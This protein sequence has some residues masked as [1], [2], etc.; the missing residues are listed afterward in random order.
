VDANTVLKRSDKVTFQTV[1]GE[2]ILIRMDSGTYFSLNQVGT[3]F[4]QLL[5]GRSP[6]SSH[7]AHIAAKYNERTQAFFAELA[8]LAAQP[9]EASQ[10][11]ITNLA[12]NYNLSEAMVRENRNRL[13][14]GQPAEALVRAYSVED[15]MVLADLLELAQKL[16]AE[17]L[18]EEG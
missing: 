15:S 2:A 17:K 7:A 1:A 10:Q 14:A 13:A 12:Q 11:A 4:W 8:A 3:D 18:V 5:D 16:A 9:A 6:I